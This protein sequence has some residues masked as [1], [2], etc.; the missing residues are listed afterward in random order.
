MQRS[1]FLTEEGTIIPVKYRDDSQGGEA[2]SFAVYQ[3]DG[4]LSFLNS[5]PSNGCGME[6]LRA[7]TFSEKVDAS[8]YLSA[9][10]AVYYLKTGAVSDQNLYQYDVMTMNLDGSGRKNLFSE[11]SNPTGPSSALFAAHKGKL[12][13][14]IPENQELIEYDVA[15]GEKKSI[16]TFEGSS[17]PS[18]IFFAGDH[19][20]IFFPLYDGKTDV[21]LTWTLGDDKLSEWQTNAD[22]VY[23]DETSY[24]C[25]KDNAT[26]LEM[27][28]KEPVQ[29]LDS[30]TG[31][32][33]RGYCT[34]G[35]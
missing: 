28:E 27:D 7:C 31:H 6:N 1:I 2:N 9:G 23:I 22:S 34:S 10:N 26:W 19:G 17:I 15:S 16:F 11:A 29:L 25:R 13:F 33:L 14:C 32:F 18:D 5:D 20:Y 30:E 4:S 35:G 8:D 21:T 12:Y 3:K 24:I